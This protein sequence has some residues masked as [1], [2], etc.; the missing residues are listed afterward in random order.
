ML[1]PLDQRPP[2]PGRL[3]VAVAVDVSISAAFAAAADDADDDD[4]DCALF[5]LLALPGLLSSSRCRRR[6]CRA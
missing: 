1:K 2:A 3:I 4:D 6:C 5:A